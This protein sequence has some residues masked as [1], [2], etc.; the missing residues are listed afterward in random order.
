[1]PSVALI[2]LNWNG[3]HDTAPCFESLR[4]SRGVN[5]EIYLVDNGSANKEAAR[6]EKEFC[7]LPLRV[8]ALPEN[9]G[10][11]AGN[12]RGLE[13][14]LKAKAKYFLL[15]NND[16][17]IPTDFLKKMVTAMEA[18]P[19]L[20]VLGAVNLYEADRKRIWY[21]GG[22]LNRSTADF[23]DPRHNTTYIPSDRIEPTDDVAGSSLM[24]TRTA[25]EQVGLLDERF[26][27]NFEESDLCLRVR[28]AGYRIACHMGAFIYHKVSAATG[29]TGPAK[30]DIN[31]YFFHRNKV[32][33]LRKHWSFFAGAPVLAWHSI[34]SLRR[35]RYARSRGNRAAPLILWGLRDGFKQNYWKGSLPAIIEWRKSFPQQPVKA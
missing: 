21:T 5:F 34:M 16:T 3:Y 26:F 2:I 32:L 18:D 7:D 19:T 23:T 29:S 25:L 12:N 11:A 28:D 27:N 22:Y 8:I 15:L 35:Y 31:E 4:K 24:I 6:L 1:M 10:F 9:L 20:G 17:I 13:I 30:I 14:A 33:F